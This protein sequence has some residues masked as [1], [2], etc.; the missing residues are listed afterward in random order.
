MQGR[1]VEPDENGQLQ[2]EPGDYGQAADG[3][4][5][6]SPPHGG[7]QVVG[8]DDVSEHRDGTI[9]VRGQISRRGW[10]GSLKKGVWQVKKGR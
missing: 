3:V 9:S 7:V 5:W 10:T 8:A 2:L 4:W 6:V 1:R